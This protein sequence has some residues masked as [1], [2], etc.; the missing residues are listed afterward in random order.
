[1]LCISQATFFLKKHLIGGLLAVSESESLTVMAAS[2]VAGRLCP[3]A[4]AE[5]SHDPQIALRFQKSPQEP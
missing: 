4:V 5:H 2:L 1:M 3:G